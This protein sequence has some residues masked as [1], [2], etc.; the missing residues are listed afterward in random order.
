[1]FRRSMFSSGIVVTLLLVAVLLGYATD[2]L[3]TNVDKCFY[4]TDFSEEVTAYAAQY[5]YEVEVI[6]KKVY[7]GREISST[8]IKE[9]LQKGNTELVNTLLGYEYSK[10]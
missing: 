10:K 8:F 9:E 3:W 6:E 7:Q 5:D 2:L 4:P 1:M